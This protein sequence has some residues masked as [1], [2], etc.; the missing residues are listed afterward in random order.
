MIHR[1]E[2]KASWLIWEER[3]ERLTVWGLKWEGD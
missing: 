2:L 3:Q 1:E